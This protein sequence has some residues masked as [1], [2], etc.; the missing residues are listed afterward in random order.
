MR[1][2][3]ELREAIMCRDV[4]EVKHLIDLGADVCMEYHLRAAVAIEA[5]KIADIIRD[6]LI[7]EFEKRKD[8]WQQELVDIKDFY[9]ML[10]NGRP[11]RN[12]PTTF[13]GPS[14]EPSPEGRSPLPTSRRGSPFSPVPLKETYPGYIILYRAQEKQEFLLQ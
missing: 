5:H 3:E 11:S 13:G 9:N 14:I 7:P 4:R 1:F 6:N 8:E 2:R 12:M 10:Y